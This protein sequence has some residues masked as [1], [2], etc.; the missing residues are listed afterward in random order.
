MHHDCKKIKILNN[1]RSRRILIILLKLNLI[2]GWSNALNKNKFPSFLVHCNFVRKKQL[3]TFLKPNR[4]LYVKLKFLD[5][6][7]K[8]YSSTTIYL[9]TSKGILSAKEAYNLK[10]GGIL[11][12]ALI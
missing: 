7:V 12:F 8:K 3:H 10:V 4:Q 9:S 1:K 5:K 2:L 6:I 11:L